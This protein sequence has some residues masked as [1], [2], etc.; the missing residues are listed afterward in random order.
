MR[1]SSRRTT[2]M[3][4]CADVGDRC[5]TDAHDVIT[6]ARCAPGH[7]WGLSLQKFLPSSQA[8]PK[9]SGGWLFSF[10]LPSLSPHPSLA[11]QHPDL[12]WVFL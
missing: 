1:Y 4:V 7:R 5:N 12:S 6:P 3:R 8:A 9:P 2:C 11:Y 10:P